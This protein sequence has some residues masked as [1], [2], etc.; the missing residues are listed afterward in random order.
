MVGKRQGS[1]F[2]F[3]EKAGSDSLRKMQN[4]N[5]NTKV[6]VNQVITKSDYYQKCNNGLESIGGHCFPGNS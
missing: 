5:T 2:T 6:E 4:I 3:N 1:F